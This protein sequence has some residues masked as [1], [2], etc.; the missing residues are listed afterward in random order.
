M[1]FYF[2]IPRSGAMH[3]ILC[4]LFNIH[5]LMFIPRHG[6]SSLPKGTLRV[7]P[8]CIPANVAC[9]YGAGKILVGVSAVPYNH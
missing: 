6:E 9:Q 1:F 3:K 4:S 8:T 5:F 2:E 7:A